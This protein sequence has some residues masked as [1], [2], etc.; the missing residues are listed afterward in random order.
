MDIRWYL[1]YCKAG[2]EKKVCDTL[3]K[4]KIENY[5]PLNRVTKV[6]N[7]RVREQA[8]FATYVFTQASEIDLNDIK[9]IPGVINLV[10][11]LGEPVTINSF[12]INSI[13]NFLRNNMNVTVEKVMV[14]NNTPKFDSFGVENE[15]SINNVRRVVLARLGLMMTAKVL[16]SGFSANEIQRAELTPVK[17]LSSV[18]NFELQL[19]KAH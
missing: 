9:R 11:W 3:T 19:Q 7:Y 5:F 14:R 10:H 1:L 18:H 2:S 8:L 6:Y 13:K 15:N 16:N 17:F 12:E 4:K